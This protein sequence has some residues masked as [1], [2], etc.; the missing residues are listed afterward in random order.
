MEIRSGEL[1]WFPGK[2]ETQ[3]VQSTLHTASKC[4]NMSTTKSYAQ[5]CNILS[6]SC[7]HYAF[8]R[9]YHISKCSPFLPSLTIPFCTNGPLRTLSRLGQC[10]DYAIVRTSYSPNQYRELIELDT[11]SLSDGSTAHCGLPLQPGTCIMPTLSLVKI[12]LKQMEDVMILAAVSRL[13]YGDATWWRG[14]IWTNDSVSYIRGCHNC[15]SCGLKFFLFINC[16]K[17]V[18]LVP[19]AYRLLGF[20]YC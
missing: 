15:R 1:I 12:Q 7:S 9:P 6:L 14:A 10:E 20:L 17:N 19:L 4:G 11:K 13:N 16:V 2:H 18:T 8:P 5:Y 3:D